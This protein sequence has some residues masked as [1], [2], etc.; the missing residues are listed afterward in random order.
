[1]RS[2][3]GS[4]IAA[5][6]PPPGVIPDFE[7]GENIAYR[8]FIVAIFFSVLSLL[9]VSA[10]LFSAHVILKKWHPDDVLI[11]VAWIIALANSVIAMVQTKYGLGKH[12]W[13]NPLEDFQMFLKIGIIGGPLTY[14]LATLFIKTSILSFYLRFSVERAFRL[15]VYFVMV[16]TVGY[17]V[18]NAILV[19]YACRPMHAYWDF[20]AKMA[21]SQCVNFDATFHTANTLNMLTD[22]AILLLPI[23]MLRP[24][25]VPLSKKIGVALILMAGGF[26]C[27]VSL[28]RM[29]TALIGINDPDISF[30]YLDNLVWWIVEM[31]FG[32]VCA[33]LPCIK[34]LVKHYFPNMPFFDSPDLK[35]PHVT[36]S[37]R[38][39]NRIAHFGPRST[40]DYDSCTLPTSEPKSKTSNMLRP[41][42]SGGSGSSG[43]E[44]VLEHVE[45]PLGQQK[46]GHGN[47]TTMDERSIDSEA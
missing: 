4:I 10:R 30:H 9:S 42:A 15:A 25:Q 2:A 12:M 38:L 41:K 36:L 44:H 17:T 31:D 3:N 11:L 27:A 18:P 7:N 21:G 20:A 33:C 28:M 39:S 14:N 23:W 47:S 6:P 35:V 45:K 37:F 26:V 8:L 19:L 34:P 40:E 32:I 24:M 16:V 13:D 29:I 43:S 22:F 46:Q 5:L 1:M